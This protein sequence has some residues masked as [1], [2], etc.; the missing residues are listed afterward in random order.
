MAL[1]PD[2]ALYIASPGYKLSAFEPT[3]AVRFQLCA[4]E[5]TTACVHPNRCWD[6]IN[7]VTSAEPWGR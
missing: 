6:W 4:A 3:G 7:A 2:G 5:L 1:A